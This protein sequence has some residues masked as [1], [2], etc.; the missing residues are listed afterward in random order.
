ME[1]GVSPVSCLVCA[2]YM[3]EGVTLKT[4]LDTHP[5]DQIIA[6]SVRILQETAQTLLKT[7]AT[8]RCYQLLDL[9]IRN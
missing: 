4:H 6:A 8:I 5:K 7:R 3:R 2:L 1:N 9:A